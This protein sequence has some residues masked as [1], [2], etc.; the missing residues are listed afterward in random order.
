MDGAVQQLAIHTVGGVVTPAQA[1]M[2]VVRN[3]ES[4]EV[5][6]AV[7][8]NDI[9]FIKPGQPVTL[10]VEIFPYTRY[11]YLQRIVETVSHGAAQDEQLGLVFPARI[12]LHEAELIV[13]GMTVPL[14]PGMSLSAEIKTGKRRLIVFCSAHC[15]GMARKHGESDDYIESM[16]ELMASNL[17]MK[18]NNKIIASV[19]SLSV[20]IGGCRVD[21]ECLVGDFFSTGNPER[22][23]PI[24]VNAVAEKYFQ[25]GMSRESMKALLVENGF[26][27]AERA[28]SKMPPDCSECEPVFMSA[29]RDIEGGASRALPEYSMVVQIGFQG[30][31]SRSVRGWVVKNA[32]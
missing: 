3:Q 21:N 6:V 29:R 22:H 15:W 16:L 14:T 19:M 24:E 2:S 9:G 8:N 18:I 13:G 27:V 1:L 10:K 20:L 11:G 30:G 25:K 12:R 31:K 26:A 17:Y 28:I 32:Y 7:L 5:E 4:L 23:H